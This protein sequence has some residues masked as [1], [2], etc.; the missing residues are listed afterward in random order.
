[1][2]TRFASTSV[3]G[4]VPAFAGLLAFLK[5]KLTGD[6][7]ARLR[8][9]GLIQVKPPKIAATVNAMAAL[10]ASLTATGPGVKINATAQLDAIAIIQAQLLAYASL[11]AALGAA[12]VEA[13]EYDGTAAAFGGEVAG[14]TARGLPGGLPSDHMNAL[15]LATR[16]PATWD[17]LLKV[18]IG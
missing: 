17:A 3:G 9:S 2:I 7:S 5:A 10:A 15:V 13:Y 4:V 16:I 1:M 11:L 8:L 6:L 18:L 14:E 12:G